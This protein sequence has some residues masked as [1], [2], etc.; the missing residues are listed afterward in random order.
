MMPLKPHYPTALKRLPERKAM[1]IGIGVLCSTRPKPHEPRPDAI[2]M[3]ADTMGSTETDSTDDLHKMYVYP[4]ER[5]VGVCAGHLEMAADLITCIQKEFKELQ[6]RTHGQYMTALNK[7]V[8]G[9][10]VQHFQ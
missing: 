3:I 1:T 9:H 4:E 7:A 8:Y 6:T 5:L 10:R 2:V